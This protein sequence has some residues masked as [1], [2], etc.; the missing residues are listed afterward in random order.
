[1]N[2][3][4]KNM[5]YSNSKLFLVLL[6]LCSIG[7][8]GCS[9]NEYT[10]SSTINNSSISNEISKNVSSISSFNTTSYNTTSSFISSNSEEINSSL[11]EIIEEEDSGYGDFH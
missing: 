5:M 8:G 7:L 6:F 2:G 3:I 4:L 1:M 11:Y 10:P 9:Y